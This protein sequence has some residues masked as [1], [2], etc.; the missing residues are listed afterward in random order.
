MYP[1]ENLIDDIDPHEYT[2]MLVLLVFEFNPISPEKF[3]LPSCFP[4]STVDLPPEHVLYKLFTFGASHFELSRHR[5]Y[6]PCGS[7]TLDTSHF[8]TSRLDDKALENM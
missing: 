5:T 6:T 8:E 2:N 3:L 4:R 1:R 7:L